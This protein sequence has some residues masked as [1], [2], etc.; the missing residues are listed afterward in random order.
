ME[1]YGARS[2]RSGGRRDGPDPRRHVAGRR[3]RARS[4]HGPDRGIPRLPYSFAVYYIYGAGEQIV[5][6]KLRI[7]IKYDDCSTTYR[8]GAFKERQDETAYGVTA[9]ILI[10]TAS[11]SRHVC[12]T[13]ALP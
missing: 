13:R 7:C 6:K 2:G 12:L 4:N 8:R 5:C 11:R 9:A 3:C 10:P 1:T